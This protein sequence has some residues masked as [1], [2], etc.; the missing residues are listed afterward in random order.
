MP[1]SDEEILGVAVFGAFK[2]VGYYFAVRWIARYY[3]P[4]KLPSALVVALSRIVLGAIVAWLVISTVDVGRNLSWYLLLVLARGLEWGVVLAY[5][6][7]RAAGGI[8]WRRLAMF[9]G[10][11][12]V[13]S[14]VL[15]LPAVFGAILV[16]M[17]AYGFC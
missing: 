17:M 5:F 10:F 15:D 12:T 13:A 2:L 9:A 1:F 11:G 3:R 7:E 8:E 6:Y 16:P 14:C 4:H